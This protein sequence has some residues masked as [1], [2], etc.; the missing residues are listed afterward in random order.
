MQG[1]CCSPP[2]SSPPST[3]PRAGTVAVRVSLAWP[4]SLRH[5][6]CHRASYDD[7]M[8][9]TAGKDSAKWLVWLLRCREQGLISS[10]T[11]SRKRLQSC[12]QARKARPFGLSCN[13]V[14]THGRHALLVYLAIMY[15]GTQGTPLWPSMVCLS[16][17]LSVLRSSV[18]YF[19]VVF[20]HTDM[21]SYTYWEMWCTLM[22]LWV[23]LGGRQHGQRTVLH[24][25]SARSVSFCARYCTHATHM[26]PTS[27]VS[28]HPCNPHPFHTLGCLP[29]TWVPSI[30]VP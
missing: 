16:P 17:T 19:P 2:G 14:R 21:I 28:W 4:V 24:E 23:M 25:R 22:E 6:T 12:T 15:A 26:Q 30:Q 8:C 29:Y 9:E 11:G 20:F 18:S 27:P 1:V 5:V 7:R 10:P 3:R 13:H